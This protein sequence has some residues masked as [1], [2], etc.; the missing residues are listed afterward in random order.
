MKVDYPEAVCLKC[1]ETFKPP[2]KRSVFCSDKC[3]R[4]VV[5]R[6]WIKFRRKVCE[7]CNFVPVHIGQLDVD[8][9]DGNKLNNDPNNLETLC[10]NCHRLKTKSRL[11]KE[12]GRPFDLPDFI[13][14]SV[15]AIHCSAE[16]VFYD[17]GNDV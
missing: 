4:R 13:S 14:L 9:K 15:V 11:D 12:I 3:R 16:W 1:H 2:S 6:P 17:A 5:K 10:A 7:R 8:H